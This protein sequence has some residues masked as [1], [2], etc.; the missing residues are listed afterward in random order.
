MET[1]KNIKQTNGYMSVPVRATDCIFILF[2][3]MEMPKMVVFC[4]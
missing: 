2:M 4:C 3:Y 1:L